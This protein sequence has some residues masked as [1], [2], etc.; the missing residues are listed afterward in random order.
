MAASEELLKIAARVVMQQMATP[1]RVAFERRIIGIA[2]CGAVALIVIIAAVMCGVAALRLW[3]TPMLGA[4][5]AA[6]VTMAILVVIALILGLTAVA[7]ARRAPK[8][9]FR[10]A[11]DVKEISNL[12]EGHMPQL[13]IAAAI[14]GLLFGMKRRK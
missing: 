14:G 5:T 9:A 1:Y 10:E 8:A 3:L 4:T 7:L 12:I 6:L 2:I 11:F 13:V